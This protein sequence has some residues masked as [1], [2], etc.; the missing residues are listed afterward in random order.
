MEVGST[1]GGG[2]ELL[3]DGA[4]EGDGP[5]HEAPA[6]EEALVLHD[7]EAPREGEGGGVVADAVARSSGRRMTWARLSFAS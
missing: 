1:S 3:L 4:H 7:F 6:S 2:Q 5:F